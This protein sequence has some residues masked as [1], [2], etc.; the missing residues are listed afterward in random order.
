MYKRVGY[1]SSNQHQ[2]TMRKVGKAENSKDQRNAYGA[3]RVDASQYNSWQEV[4]INKV[5]CDRPTRQGTFRLFPG[6]L[7][8]PGHFR[9]FDFDHRQGHSPG[10]LQRETAWHFVQP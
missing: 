9:L 7:I 4:K 3:Q 5:H 1:V 8:S 2:L 10:R 6:H